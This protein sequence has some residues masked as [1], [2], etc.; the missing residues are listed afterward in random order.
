[1]FTIINFYAVFVLIF[2]RTSGFSK[3]AFTS[4]E[5]ILKVLDLQNKVPYLLL[6]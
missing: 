2:W 5:V 4:E 3:P 1:M 6:F